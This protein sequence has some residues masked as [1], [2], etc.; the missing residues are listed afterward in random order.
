[1]QESFSHQTQTSIN[2]IQDD[3]IQD[4]DTPSTGT[5]RLKQNINGGNYIKPDEANITCTSKMNY[6]DPRPEVD[7]DV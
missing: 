1:M 7:D 5:I 3:N 4:Q 6:G 2:V